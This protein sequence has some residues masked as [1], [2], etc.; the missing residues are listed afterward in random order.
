MNTERLTTKSREAITGAVALASQRGH[1]TVEPLHLLLALLDTEGSTAAGLLRAVGADPADVRRAALRAVERAAR[2]PAASTIAAPTLSR[3]F[4]NAIGAAEQSRGR[5]AT[6]T[7]P[8]STC[9]SGWPGRRRGRRPLLTGAGATAEALLAAFPHRPRRRPQGHHRRPGGHLPG[10]GEVRRRPHRAR[11]RG[12]DRPGDRPGRRDPPGRPGAVPADQEQPGADRRARRRQ[13]RR[14][15]GP[16]PADRRRRRAGVAAGQAADLARPRRDG[17][18]REVPRR[19]R[20]AAEGRARGD[21]GLRRARSSPSST[22]CTPS[23]AP[24]RPARARWTPATCSSRCWPAASCGWSAPPRSTSTASTSR[25]TRRWSAASSRCWSASRPS[26]TPSASC[27]GSRSATRRTTGCGS[28]TPR[29]SPRRRCPTATSP[30]ASCRTRRS[31]WSTRPRPGC[32]WRSTP[33]RSRST[34]CSARS[35]G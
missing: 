35:T 23:S 2:A 33:G 26:R 10:A 1:A 29:W 12:Q 4:L 32:A 17:G 14:R 7:S 16:G 18:R 9:W 24:A 31:T 27:A 6:S 34:S 21:Q 30:P 19:V 11:P 22:S 5:S 15:R 20:G 28:P 8:P 13:D 3:E 25:R